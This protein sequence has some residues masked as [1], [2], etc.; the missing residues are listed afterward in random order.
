VI[1][2][3]QPLQIPWSKLF[4]GEPAPAGKTETAAK[5]VPTSEAER[6]AESAHEPD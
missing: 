6:A 4:G 1:G 5:P 3:D 2:K